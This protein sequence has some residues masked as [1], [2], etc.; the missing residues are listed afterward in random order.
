[1]IMQNDYGVYKELL[2]GTEEWLISEDPLEFGSYTD[3]ID[4]LSFA[5]AAAIATYL[6]N[7]Q[8][9]EF[10]VGRPNDRHPS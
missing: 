10:K 6:T 3:A 7:L 1:M 5:E 4:N 8:G 9:S 2:D